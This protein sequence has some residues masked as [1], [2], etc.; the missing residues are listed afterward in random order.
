VD[1][2]VSEFMQGATV[3]NANGTLSY[4]APEMFSQSSFAGP[5]LDV[6]A[7]GVILFAMLCGYL[8]FDGSPDLSYNGRLPDSQVGKNIRACEYDPAETL[9]DGAVVS[10][11]MFVFVCV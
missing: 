6:W 11:C 3:S 5:P 10:T 7:L 1:F 8:P 2:G 4:F 9:S